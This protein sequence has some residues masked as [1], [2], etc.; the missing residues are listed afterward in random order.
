[1]VTII[2]GEHYKYVHFVALPPLLFD[3]QEDPNEFNNLANDPA[4]QVI[5][6]ECARKLLSWRMEHEAPSLTDFQ[7]MG[8]LSL[9]QGLRS[10]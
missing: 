1:V 9:E 10:K 3:L 6:L 5:A 7:L 2:R 4:Y 8:G